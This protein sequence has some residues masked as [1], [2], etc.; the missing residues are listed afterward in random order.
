M[1]EAEQVPFFLPF[2][3]FFFL[4]YLC[5]AFALPDP[6]WEGSF[7]GSETSAEQETDLETFYFSTEHRRWFFGLLGGF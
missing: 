5:C 6:D 4:L 2:L 7:D 1:S 3:L